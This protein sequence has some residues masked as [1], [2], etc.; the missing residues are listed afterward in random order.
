MGG[1]GNRAQALHGATDIHMVNQA[2]Q[3]AR[4][5]TA[6]AVDSANAKAAFAAYSGFSC[7]G[8]S[9]CDGLGHIF[10][11][12]NSGASWIQVDGNLPDVPVNDIV[13]DPTDATD[14]TI[15][16]ATDA[17]VYAS[18]NATAGSAT[19]WSVLQSGL[20]NS[21]VMSLRLR[22]ASRRWWRRRMGAAC[23]ARCCRICRDSR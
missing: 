9:G 22:N 21:Q 17:G 2:N 23:G 4:S 7:P 20:P 3:P 10:F 5:V 13:I 12:N 16:I 6:I 1:Y 14:N 15:Y 11:T 18:A 19:T 8:V